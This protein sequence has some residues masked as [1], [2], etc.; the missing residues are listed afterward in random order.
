MSCTRW[1]QGRRD[2]PGWAI[3]ETESERMAIPRAKFIGLSS[4]DPDRYGLPRNVGITLNDKDVGRA[5]ELLEYR[6]SQKKDW[7]GRDRVRA[8]VRARRARRQGLPLP[9]QDLPAE[10]A[11]RG[12][13]VGLGRAPLLGS[14]R[15]QDLPGAFGKL[16]FRGRRPGVVAKT[17]CTARESTRICDVLPNGLPRPRARQVGSTRRHDAH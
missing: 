14:A 13:L 6:W 4:A 16:W 12:R 8:Q 9:D 15:P 1:R 3:A 5:K 11:Q 7:A 2:G 17:I 10:E